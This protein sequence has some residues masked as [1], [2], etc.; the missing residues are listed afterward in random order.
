MSLQ[1]P[2]THESLL[3]DD[4]AGKLTRQ[5]K[6]L[7]KQGYEMEKKLNISYTR[8]SYANFYPK[9]DGPGFPR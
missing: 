1:D 2:F 7:A 5:E 9:N 4:K 3:I 6:R 8:P